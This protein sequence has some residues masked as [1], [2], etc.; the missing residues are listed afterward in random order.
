MQRLAGRVA[1]ATSG[2]LEN[3][4]EKR[5]DDMELGGLEP[6]THSLGI[7]AHLLIPVYQCLFRA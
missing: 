1:L 6:P 7:R 4:P 3:P 2:D 5:V